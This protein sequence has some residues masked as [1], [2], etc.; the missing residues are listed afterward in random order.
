[1]KFL[2]PELTWREFE[3]HCEDILFTCIDESKFRIN[4]QYNRQYSDGQNF[5]MDCHIAERRQG[6][7]GLVIDF[8]HFPVAKLNRHEILSA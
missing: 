1:M 6:G 8:K 5:R 3:R 4:V 7:K 2:H